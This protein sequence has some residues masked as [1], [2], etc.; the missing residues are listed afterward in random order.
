MVVYI[1][2]RIIC[3]VPSTRVINNII[4]ITITV[5]VIMVLLGIFNVSLKLC[6]GSFKVC[7]LLSLPSC[8]PA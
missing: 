6:F 8:L 3:M 1:E 2:S 7:S 4:I 5:T